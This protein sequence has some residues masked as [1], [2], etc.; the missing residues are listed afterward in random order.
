MLGDHIGNFDISGDVH[1]HFR[2]WKR[3]VS[4]SAEGFARNETP[5]YF[6]RRFY[7]NH[8]AWNQELKNMYRLRLQGNLHIPSWGTSL[9]AGVENISNYVYFNE[10]A[11]S[12]QYEGQL[13]VMYAQW[14][15]AL[16]YGVFHF[17]FNVVG[18]LSSRQE[19]LPLPTLAA[20][21]NLYV[22]TLF[23]KVMHAQIG[24]DCRYFTS[25]FIP[26]YNPAL[27]QYYLQ[28]EKK[29]GDYPYMNVYANMHLKRARFF[30]MYT[31]G[32]RLFA[33]PNYF[34]TLHYPQNPSQIKAGI[35]WNFYD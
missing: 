10:K 20:Y 24:I 32:S 1:S 35:S 28:T 29:V 31:H 12:T 6:Y 9:T 7:S 8:Y 3:L 13:Q 22:K 16:S 21:G 4:V 2:L 14:K 27:G 23:S 19:V 5:D 34:T 25:Y 11:Q 26:A 15:Q 18:Q 30:I 17:D 33:D